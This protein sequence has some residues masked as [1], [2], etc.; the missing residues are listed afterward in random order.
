MLK[1]IYT[2]LHSHLLSSVTSRFSRNEDGMA[3]IEFGIIAPIMI[4]MYFGLAEIASAIS[5]D[6]QISHSANVG[7]D[8]ATQ[9]ESVSVDEMSEIMTA[10]MLVMGIPSDRQKGVTVE[11][12]SYARAS[13]DSI[14]EKGK[15]VLKGSEAVDLPTFNAAELDDHILNDV[16]GAVVA[17]V[18]YVY[19]PLK[20]R[21][22][23]TDVNLSEVFTLKPRKSDNVDIHELDGSGGLTSNNYTCSFADGPVENDNTG[24]VSCLA[25]GI[26]N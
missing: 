3:A 14:I 6:R 21:F 9:L 15:A 17:R 1:Q 24:K 12:A 16:T 26:L 13:D 20:L 7:G 18:N 10:T 19:Q 4:A 23:N 25:S 8:L 5:I 11:I 22:L 2:S